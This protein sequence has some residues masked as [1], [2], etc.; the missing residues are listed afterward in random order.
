VGM[1]SRD[2]LT[3]GRRVFSASLMKMALLI[4]VLAACAPAPSS[5]PQNRVAEQPN[6]QAVPRGT[7]KIAWPFE[8]ENLHP[9]L[10]FG[11]GVTDYFWTFDSTLAIRDFSGAPHPVIAR[12]LPTQANGD[13]I[14]NPDGTMVTT[15]RLRENAK[16][17]D[18][19]PLTARDF[20]FAYEVYLDGEIPVQDRSSELLMSKVE[21]RDDHTLVINWKEPF[22]GAG[23]LGFRQLN[24]M[25]THIFEEKYRTNHA[26]F[27]FGEEW[28]V[29]YVGSGPFRMERW[30]P[31][32]CWAHRSLTRSRFAS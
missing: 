25:A 21:A 24:P 1:C 7:L 31:G 3:L 16:W 4:S 28:T 13:W 10:L 9:K 17:H 5:P 19:T 30:E 11:S 32:S 27:A 14:V 6:A 29:S 18:G 23:T 15:Y 22:I 26:N 2:S 8:P 20:A 12:E